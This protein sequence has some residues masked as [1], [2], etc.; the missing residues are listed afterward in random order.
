MAQSLRPDP[1]RSLGCL[2]L[3]DLIEI[4]GVH[5]EHVDMPPTVLYVAV[6]L[7]GE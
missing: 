2:T 4:V 7:L 5:V 1:S 6:V 3:G